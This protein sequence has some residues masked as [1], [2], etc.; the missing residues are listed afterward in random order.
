VTLRNPKRG[1]YVIP[2]EGRTF[3]DI[4]YT[5][6]KFLPIAK[7]ISTNRKRSK[8]V[9]VIELT[10]K[11]GQLTNINVDK[12][13]FKKYYRIVNQTTANILYGDKNGTI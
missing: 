5:N 12:K 11:N 8:R 6:V 3:S 10:L 4:Y 13:H 2:K 9:Y 1:D 7:V